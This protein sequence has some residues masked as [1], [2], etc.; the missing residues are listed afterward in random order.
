MK[1]KHGRHPDI[2]LILKKDEVDAAGYLDQITDVAVEYCNKLGIND[3]NCNHLAT[4]V[5]VMT[6]FPELT[7]DCCQKIIDVYERNEE[8]KRIN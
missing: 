8:T 2:G 5:S 4:A 3:E 1:L 6:L 7:R